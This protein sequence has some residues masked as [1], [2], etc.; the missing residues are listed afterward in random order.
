MRRPG[1]RGRAGNISLEPDH[2]V[3]KER[4]MTEKL[5]PAL[6]SRTIEMGRLQSERGAYKLEK[7]KALKDQVDVNAE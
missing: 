6:V 5:F 4:A 1:R 2:L 7:K 3:F